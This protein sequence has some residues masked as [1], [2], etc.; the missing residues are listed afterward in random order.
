MSELLQHD[1]GVALLRLRKPL[2]HYVKKYGTPLYGLHKLHLLMHKQHNR[3]QDGVGVASIALKA[4][5]GTPLLNSWREIGMDALQRMF[6]SFT[7]TFDEKGLSN[8]RL[9]E[10]VLSWQR[11]YPFLG[12]LL[13]GHL[14]YATHGKNEK[15]QCHPFSRKSE[16]R[17]QS[18]ILAGNFHMANQEALFQHLISLGQHPSSSADAPAV[19]E[20]VGYHLD[21]EVEEL[22]D[23]Y[24]DKNLSSAEL[25]QEIEQHLPLVKILK[26]ACS[27]FDGGYVL[28]GALGHGHAF[29]F[30]DP[31]GIRPAYY[32][33]DDEIVV[34]TSEKP[35]IKTAFG[36][37]F[38]KIRDLP[39][40]H[41]L[42]CSP[43]GEPD[44]QP[45]FPKYTPKS[46]S[47]ER[48]YFSRASDPEIYKE[49]KT[50]GK[51]LVPDLIKILGDDIE[52]AI[53]SYVPNTAEIAFLGLIEELRDR[54]GSSPRVE[55]L[56]SKDMKMRTFIVKGGRREELVRY[57]YDT[58]YG[59]I[60]KEKDVLVILDDSI[61]RGTTLSQSILTLLFQLLPK[62]I[63]ILS[64]APQIRY[65][66]CYG[67]DMNRFEEFIAF[68]A[69]MSILTEDPKDQLLREVYEK[70]KA[71]LNS[72]L[73]AIKN[74]VTDLYKAVSGWELSERMALLLHPNYKSGLNFPV[75][76]DILFQRIEGLHKACPKHLGDWY[77][78]GEYPTP[79]GARTANQAFIRFIESNPQGAWFSKDLNRLGT[80]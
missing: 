75:R 28:I 73:G 48:I 58:T 10:R 25:T 11:K 26:E 14:R 15:N 2:Q 53:F 52:Q 47:F 77:F 6:F 9:G 37:E 8:L 63:V 62:R 1:C 24:R 57:T 78:T 46:C 23:K 64:S 35:P 34:L 31:H 51:N 66:D 27:A 33:W 69:L 71:S 3:G 59:L 70:A 60:K 13:L 45:L 40:G 12:E 5:P 21:K 80:Q 38:S 74:H 39:P 79:Y 29:A 32:Y 43:E 49:R 72:P 55:R 67:I 68:R 54:L 56:I 20:R 42:L 36:I 50:L 61:V 41:V 76:L 44:I 7:Q 16:W 65:P 17:Y 4:P 30:R 19:M 22:K 18:L